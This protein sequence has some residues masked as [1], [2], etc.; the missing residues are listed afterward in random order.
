MQ[1]THDVL[2]VNIPDAEPNLQSLDIYSPDAPQNL[3][4]VVVWVHGGGWMA[5]DKQKHVED[6][7]TFFTQLGYVF[8]SVNY[9][10]SPDVHHP[11]HTQDVAQSIAWLQQNVA[12]Y[13]GDPKRIILMGHSAGGHI[14]SLLGTNARF[15]LELGLDP[16]VIKGILVI[17]GVGF[18]V[19]ARMRSQKQGFSRMYTQAFGSHEEDW[20]D[21]SPILHIGTH[22]Y[23]PRYLMLCADHSNHAPVAAQIFWEALKEANLQAEVTSIS[24]KDHSTINEDIGKYKEVINMVIEDFLKECFG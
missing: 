9:R 1:I 8:A 19:Q 7:A 16:Q 14:V 12:N 20:Q 3:C 24:N 2:Y 10:L 15:L 17:D 4:P 22:S 21:A 6:K 11:A 23:T 18:D 13:G 5:S